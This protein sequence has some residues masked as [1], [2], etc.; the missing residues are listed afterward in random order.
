M[1]KSEIYLAGGCFWGLQKYMDSEVAG[2]LETEVGYANGW[3]ENVKYNDLHQMNTGFCET[4]KVIYDSDTI[5][6]S[7]LLK[8]YYFT[9]DPTTLNRQGADLGTQYRTGIFYT[10]ENDRPIIEGSL[11]ELQNNFKERIVVECKPLTKYVK[12]E[13][14]HQKYLDYNPN[15]YCH[16]NI[17]KIRR[18][19]KLL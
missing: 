7:D 19:K 5:S 6:L 11:A 17:E 8:E 2:V 3:S 18:L 9:I 10:D 1:K 15:G 12:A 14:Y 13:E 16:I 4:V